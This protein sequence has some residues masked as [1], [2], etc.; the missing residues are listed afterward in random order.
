MIDLLLLF[1]LFIGVLTGLKRG[2]IL[3]LFHLIGFIV[4]FV[5]AV[6]YYDDLSPKLTLWV[7]YPELPADASWAVFLDNLPLEQAFYN[8]VA[9]AIL[10]FGVKIVLHIIA[11]MLDFVSELPILNSLNTLLGGILGFVENYVILFVVLYIAALVPVAGVQ[12]ALDGSL[13]AQLIIEHTPVLSN[14]LENLWIEH[15]AG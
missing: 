1:L 15:V 9:F 13:L 8:A 3:Q 7:P 4:A 2:F 14:Q 6:I 5:A 10:F 12:S 11:S